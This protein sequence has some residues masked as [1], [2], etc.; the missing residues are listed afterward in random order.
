MFRQKNLSQDLIIKIIEKAA[1]KIPQS[2]LEDF[3]SAIEKEKNNHYFTKSSESNLLRIILNQFDIAFFVNECLKFPHQIEILI[4][5][6]NNSNYLT[7]ILVRNPEYFHWIINPSVLEFKVDDKYFKESLEKLVLPFKSF[8]SK[9]NAIRNFKRKEILRIGLKDIY[10]KTDFKIITLHLSQ[11]AVA[12]SSILF[13][14]CYSEILKKYKLEKVSNKFVVF[15]LGKLGGNELNYSSDIDLVAFYDKNTLINKKI[16][17][18][19]ILSE[20]ILLFIETASKKTG[21]GFLYRVDF[22]L[23]PDGRNAPLCRSYAEYIRY[24]E[25]RGEDWERQMLIKANYL[26]GSKN[27]YNSFFDYISKFIYPASFS[28]SP[29]DQIRKLKVSIEKRNKSEENIKLSAGG[30]RDIEFSIQALQLINGG[31]DFSLRIGNTLDVISNLEIKKI[32][33]SDEAETFKSSYI[34]YRKAEHYLQLMNDQQTHTIPANGEIA[35]KLAHFAGCKDLKSFNRL[36]K[37]SKEKVQSIYNS[38]IGFDNTVPVITDFEKIKFSDT[39][40]AKNNLEFLRTGKSILEKKQFDSRTITAFTKI[41]EQLVSFLLSSIN[42]DLVLENFVRIIKTAQFPQIW[43]EEFSDQKFLNLTLQLC[44]RSQKSIDI[45]AE[46][47]VLR[48]EYLSRECLLP[49]HTSDFSKLSLKQFYFRCSVQLTAN[50]L[51]PLDFSSVY[52][53]Y[54]NQVITYLTKDYVTDKQWKNIFFIAAM[55]SFGSSELSFASDSDLIFVV[56]EIHKFPTIQKDFQ[57]LLQLLRENLPSLE[58]DCRLRPE[59][60]SSPLVWDVEDYKKYFSN[61]ARVWELQAFTKCRLIFGDDKLFDDFYNHY[62]KRIKDKEP[63]LIK[64]EMIE[65]RKKLLPINDD[66]INLKKSSGGLY[67]IDFI[68]SFIELT[69]TEKS[70]LNINFEQLRNNFIFLK[71]IELLN[72]N[73]FNT[74]LSKIP[75]EELK[76][77][78]LSKECGFEDYKMFIKKLNYVIQQNRKYYQEIFN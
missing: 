45:F 35:E 27:L 6:A 5:I 66:S 31:K 54:L 1:G 62:R 3:L 50:I 72:Q 24:Y 30:I 63:K 76:L 57:K 73:I 8:E 41:E 11:L 39:K 74:K 56:K 70:N 16:Y 10:L 38:I 12:I 7:D 75:T 42:P 65:M 22:R 58:I 44:E 4:S 51:S 55:G 77:K 71:Q 37:D 68:K 43:Y 47:K 20:T 34:L 46:D 32:I 40:R 19:Q 60:K 2:N 25:M 64:S 61:R 13:D 48:D 59:G 21:S 78:K 14:L 67:D 15:S 36:I 26:C 49:L 17:Y 53:D 29:V 28:I 9:T 23:R 33:S 52:S 69:Q 18:E